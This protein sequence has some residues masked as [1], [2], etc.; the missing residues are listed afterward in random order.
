MGT[1]PHPPRPPVPPPPPVSRRASHI[2]AI[3]LLVLALIV[4]VSVAAVWLGLR[5][6][7]RNVEVSV[8]EGEA[9]KKGV[10]IKTPL[11][12]LE[13]TQ[14]V[15]ESRLGLPLYPGAVRV[16]GDEGSA[17][18]NIDIAGEKSVRVLAATFQTPDAPATVQEFYRQRLADE[19]TKFIEKDQ[20]GKTVFEIKKS[21]LEKVV[22]LERRNGGTRIALVRVLHGE[23]E[24]N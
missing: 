4:T 7:S 20:D 23:A 19:V 8:Q 1:S 22:A 15:D 9:G 11:G 24:T 18:V 17:A 16:K 13:V 3:A 2:V 12:S 6:I 14:D 10:S 5:L 21:G